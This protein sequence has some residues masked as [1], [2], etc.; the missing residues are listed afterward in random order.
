LNTKQSTVLKAAI[1]VGM[2]V[3]VAACNGKK[4]LVTLDPKEMKG[5]QIPVSNL[6]KSS[7]KMN[8]TEQVEYSRTDLAQRLGVE[9]SAVEISSAQAVTWRSGALG[10]PELGVSYTD[11]LIPGASIFLRVGNTLHAYH[12]RHDGVPF[13]CPRERVEQPLLDP[14]RDVT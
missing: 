6:K 11:A 14:T 7:V 13:Y 4:E 3:G 9:K 2:A 1:L 5:A 12:S 8:L 10:C